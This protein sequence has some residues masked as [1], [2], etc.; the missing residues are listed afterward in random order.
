M[1]H[2]L[3]DEDRRKAAETRSRQ[4]AERRREKAEHARSTDAALL[5][6]RQRLGA[7][8]AETT[9]Q[10]WRTLWKGATPQAK[11]RLMDQAFGRPT[12][13]E[14]PPEVHDDMGASLTREQRAQL[15]AELE[16]AAGELPVGTDEEQAGP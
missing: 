4:A 10:E 13:A 8:I 1:A 2:K 16:Q 12:E 11:V 6:A 15:I 7:V 3:T 9:T 5:T 14:P